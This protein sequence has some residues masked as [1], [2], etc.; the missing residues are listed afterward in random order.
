MKRRFLA[1]VL[2]LMLAVTLLPTAAFADDGIYLYVNGVAF[3]QVGQTIKCG[4]GTATLVWDYW[5][6]AL[7]LENADITEFSQ[8]INSDGSAEYVGIYF[9]GSRPLTIVLKGT[10]T[11][12]APKHSSG[13]YVGMLANGVINFN[14]TDEAHPNCRLNIKGVETGVICDDGSG[15]GTV[16]LNSCSFFIDAAV[17]GI[18][19]YRIQ[20]CSDI[21]VDCRGPVGISAEYINLT[22][23][24]DTVVNMNTDSS[25]YCSSVGIMATDLS[26]SCVTVNVNS[27]MDASK[28]K[29]TD[30]VSLTCIAADNIDVSALNLNANLN[31][32]GLA[33]SQP[34]GV[35]GIVC[36][37]LVTNSEFKCNISL[38]GRDIDLAAGVIALELFEVF[39]KTDCTV[40]VSGNHASAIAVSAG[41]IDTSIDGSELYA[42]VKG[43]NKSDAAVEVYDA[44][45]LKEAYFIY[46]GIDC[47]DSDV[48]AIVAG[49]EFIPQYT[50]ISYPANGKVYTFEDESEKISIITNENGKPA[51]EVVLSRSE[52][53]F[54]D[55]G[56]LNESFKTSI[57]WASRNGITT[58]YSPT[59][60]KPSETCTR[61]QIVTFL[62]RAS[63]SPEPITTENPFVDVS[64]TGKTAPYYKAILWAY[65]SGMTTGFDATH[66]KPS[67]PCTRGQAVT[68]LW[69]AQGCPVPET[70]D[71][72]FSDVS[73]EIVYYP[74]ILWAA[75]NGI[76]AG[77]SN[78]DFK[79]NNVCSRAHIVTF[80]Y[81][82]STEAQNGKIV[83][84]TYEL[85]PEELAT[86][87]I[88]CSSV[89]DGSIRDMLG[90][91]EIVPV[92]IT[93]TYADGSEKTLSFE[94]HSLVDKETAVSEGWFE[95]LGSCSSKNTVSF[96]YVDSNSKENTIINASFK[97]D[98]ATIVAAGVKSVKY[99]GN[100][101][102][103][104]KYSCLHVYNMESGTEERVFIA[105][106]ET[107]T[108]KDS[109]IVGDM[110][111]YCTTGSTVG[112]K[113][114]WIYKANLNTFSTTYSTLVDV[115]CDCDE[116]VFSETGYDITR[117]VGDETVVTHYDY[118]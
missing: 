54:R 79:P 101:A 71:N 117:T 106:Y 16:D 35:Y 2:V 77:Y 88:W 81:R 55:V 47:A 31:S 90:D 34:A 44:S 67:N 3:T 11:I 8:Y 14:Y 28:N 118:T 20:G 4:K 24:G 38:E 82:A 93:V 109:F 105:P 72:P 17:C 92:N 19:A 61:G 12:T 22:D 50:N 5:D 76:A 57:V 62:W 48:G 10:T 18:S 30:S 96:C 113:T 52:Y 70:L 95:I 99:S 29:G 103:F 46:A 87:P 58:G 51:K 91:Y 78:G 75:E 84:I 100:F 13:N 68:F 36:S 110:V 26:T 97:N 114:V 7:I 74:A 60:F 15:G 89:D 25:K 80:L 53:S 112:E 64:A 102:V 65:E 63:G 43:A 116:V 49:G 9:A 23:F 59:V 86:R 66:F 39:G 69:R 45:S 115:Y 94:L 111:Y 42:H 56:N 107:T 33:G 6:P 108:V 98:S 41:G 27:N 32:S 1:A 21:T 85:Y 104:T 73:N 83:D 40:T 37:K